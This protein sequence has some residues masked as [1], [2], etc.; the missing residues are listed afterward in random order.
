M[1]PLHDNQFLHLLQEWYYALPLLTGLIVVFLLVGLPAH[2]RLAQFI[3]A[4]TVVWCLILIVLYGHFRESPGLACV[5]VGAI[6]WA[7]TRQLSQAA[8]HRTAQS[9]L[10]RLR[11][12]ATLLEGA[13]RDYFRADPRCGYWLDLARASRGLPAERTAAE[14]RKL[15]QL[16]FEL[17]EWRVVLWNRVLLRLVELRIQILRWLPRWWKLPVETV[18]LSELHLN[19]LLQEEIELSERQM[20]ELESGTS[21]RE[22][23]Q[24]VVRE[25]HADAVRRAGEFGRK[26]CQLTEALIESRVFVTGEHSKE[27]TLLEAAGLS[28]ELWRFRWAHDRLW[29][30]LEATDFVSDDE[31]V[32]LAEKT[33]P[34]KTQ[35][36]RKPEPALAVATTDDDLLSPGWQA[37]DEDSPWDSDADSELDEFEDLDDFAPDEIDGSEGQLDEWSAAD[38]DE[39]DDSEDDTGGAGDDIA[40]GSLAASEGDSSDELAEN[41]SIDALGQ[42]RLEDLIRACGL[43]ESWLDFELTG[44]FSQDIRRLEDLRHRP[45]NWLVTTWLLMLL[46][47]RDDCGRGRGDR[48]KN[49][50]ISRLSN[51]SSGLA[52]GDQVA[53]QVKLR[54]QEMLIDWLALRDGYTQIRE[55]FSH[56]APRTAWQWE[57]LGRANAH[58]SRNMRDH[59]G[60]RDDVM[61]DAT[62]AFFRASVTGFWTQRYAGLLLGTKTAEETIGVLQD[63]RVEFGRSD[64]DRM[65]DTHGRGQAA[66]SHAGVAE[67]A[68]AAD[69]SPPPQGREPSRKKASRRKSSQAKKQKVDSVSG[70]SQPVL[71]MRVGQKVQK[72]KLSSSPVSIGSTRDNSIRHSSLDEHHC[73]LHWENGQLQLEDLTDGFGVMVQGEL[74]EGTVELKKGSVVQCGKIRFRVKLL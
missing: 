26:R 4:I 13:V 62:I 68:D 63:H 35:L 65:L 56:T 41:V 24:R 38:G 57:L 30:D 31:Q 53:R 72:M 34:P 28:Y 70:A 40:F 2:R 23:V 61:R 15:L 66:E 16:S 11:F 44:D 9:P 10:S 50:V 58:I 74:I 22:Y 21:F 12:P 25:E 29:A 59:G 17:P 19:L 52:S 8:R 67:L 32:V 73:R 69:E 5:S 1:I 46:C 18:S 36:R 49:A 7:L 60:L 64:L 55:R 3:S 51:W 14:R 54:F 71:E 43:L 45:A 20:M 33:S 27:K 39:E 48:A 37:D 42:A 6:G 47:L